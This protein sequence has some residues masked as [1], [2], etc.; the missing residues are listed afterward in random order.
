MN[1]VE[2]QTT[3]PTG[4]LWG[5]LNWLFCINYNVTD[6]TDTDTEDNTNDGYGP[7]TSRR[8]PLGNPLGIRP[9]GDAV[10]VQRYI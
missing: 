2:A 4:T 6:D 1:D 10:P 9:Y 3:P 7:L 8:V 5:I